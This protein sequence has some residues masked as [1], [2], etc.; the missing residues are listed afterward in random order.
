MR[1]VCADDSFV[2]GG[3]WRSSNYT[4]FHHRVKFETRRRVGSDG[5]GLPPPYPGGKNFTISL[6]FLYRVSD[7]EPVKFSNL[8]THPCPSEEGIAQPLGLTM[9]TR[10]K[11]SK[12]HGLA[13]PTRRTSDGPRDRKTELTC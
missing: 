1:L 13:E 6:P 11:F 9:A 7:F 4:K 2:T 12:S 5:A 3:E 10:F 8:G